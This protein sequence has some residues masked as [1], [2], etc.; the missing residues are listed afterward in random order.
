MRFADSGVCANGRVEKKGDY[1]RV[2]I[3]RYIPIAGNVSILSMRIFVEPTF[4]MKTGLLR[5]NLGEDLFFVCDLHKLRFT[6]IYSSGL[7]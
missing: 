6:F 3:E 7:S 1:Y 2:R 5:N 4:R